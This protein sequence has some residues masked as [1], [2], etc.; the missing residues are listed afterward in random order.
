MTIRIL[1]SYHYH[2]D[3]DL[4]DLVGA[5]GGEPV[6]LFAD[7]GAYSAATTGAT[8]KLADYAAWLRH[9]EPL[10][11]VQANL[12]V[13]GDHEGTA[14]NFAQFRDAGCDPLPVFHTGEPWRVLEELCAGHPYVA[15]GGVALHAVGAAKQRKLMAWLIKA[16]QIARQPGTVFHG[17]GITSAKLVRD[18][19]F[20]SLDSSSYTF[21]Q[22]FGLVYLWDSSAWAMRSV[23]FRNPAEVRPYSALFTQHG[24]PPGK[25]INP[26]FMRAGTVTGADDRAALTAASAR[27]FQRMERSLIARHHV[28]PP[29]LPRANDAGTKVYFALPGVAP[30]D[31]APLRLIRKT[32]TP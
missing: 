19:P 20:Y 31:L 17:F 32:S 16:F 10:L 27:A 23:F 9:W 25:V 7:S 21:G 22:R 12:D 6:D 30:A 4:A 1:V 26:S 3:T 8:I 11:T 2:R 24:L 13:I 14:V 5:F 28:G 18:L 15:L 29:P